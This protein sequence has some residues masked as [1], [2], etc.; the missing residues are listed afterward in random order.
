MVE[1]KL[2]TD[3][4][5]DIARFVAEFTSRMRR[6]PM[7]PQ[8]FKPS[9]R[10]PIAIAKLLSAIRVKN[11]RLLSNDFIEAATVTSYVAIRTDV[12]RIARETLADLT[13]TSAK[14]SIELAAKMAEALGFKASDE[15]ILNLWFKRHDELAE[16]EKKALLEK[17]RQAL[18]NLGLYYAQR[19]INN[20]YTSGPGPEK[21]YAIRKYRF[22]ID[23]VTAIDFELTLEDA[24]AEDKKSEY[25]SYE[26]FR[27]RQVRRERRSVLYLQD[28]SASFDYRVLLNCAICGSML[29]YG[30]PR[31]DKTAIALFSDDVAVLKEISNREDATSLRDRLLSIKPLGGTNISKAIK[32]A[33][34]QFEQ[35]GRNHAKFCLVFSDMGFQI[36]DVER[37]LNDISK[38][39]HLG[40]KIIF[41]K[42][43]PFTH[44]Y[45]EG[46]KMLDEMGCKMVNVENILDF[47]EFV[48]RIISPN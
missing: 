31:D 29:I 18:T 42:F 35:V 44:Y 47:P 20:F 26:D 3:V 32:W 37:S 22:G 38:L 13:C 34:M 6:S 15:E 28:A 1:K 45:Q 16:E 41:L 7:I 25:L 27:T 24:I 43:K 8:A 19:F 36:D 4:Q 21:G 39:Q 30:L 33:R 11:H 23:D 46:I 40:V 14:A 12:E 9:I 17:A 2:S 5:V 48:S 10:Q